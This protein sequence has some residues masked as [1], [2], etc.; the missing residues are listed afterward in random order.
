MFAVIAL[1]LFVLA[2]FGVMI[3]GL[4]TVILGFVFLAAHHAFG[5]PIGIPTWQ[6]RQQ[7]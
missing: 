5:S 3:A 6:Q 7:Q 2:L 4:D 1:I